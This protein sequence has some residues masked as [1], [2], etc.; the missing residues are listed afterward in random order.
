M[1]LFD[2]ADNDD[3]VYKNESVGSI[4]P[5]K[6]VWQKFPILDLSCEFGVGGLRF[7]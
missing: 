2:V 5:R 1:D 4:P 7:L 6:Y 3:D